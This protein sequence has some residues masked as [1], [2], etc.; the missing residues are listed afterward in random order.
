MTSSRSPRISVIVPVRDRREL[1]REL[2][3]SLACQTFTDFEVIVV[4][5]GSRDGSGDEARSDAAAGRPVRVVPNVGV[6]AYAGRRAGVAASNAPYL[7]FTDSDCVVE[8]EWIEAGVA[9][10]EAGADVANGRTEPVR[11]PGPLE[12]TMWSGEEGLYPTCNVFYKRTAYDRVGGFDERA[13]D[14]FGFRPG[15]RARRMGFGEDTLLGWKVRRSGPAAYARDAVAHHQVLPPDIRDTFRRTWMMVAFPALFREVPELRQPP[16]VRHRVLLSTPNR[17]PLYATVA[18]LLGRRRLAAGA[19]AAWW[20][21]A[22]AR[23]TRVGSATRRQRFQALPVQLGLD[24]VAIT[25]LA[26]G[27]VRHRTIVL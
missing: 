4:D 14:R 3:D 24:V 12:R 18:A 17:L 20:V 23:D 13:A 22:R 16:L 19:S 9:A 2:L 1:L 5:D 26:I 7:A 10:L 15:T 11:S 8:R 6:G 25:A 21:A 27:S